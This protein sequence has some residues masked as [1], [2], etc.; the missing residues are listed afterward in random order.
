MLTENVHDV[1]EFGENR[2]DHT[3]H[4]SGARPTIRLTPVSELVGSADETGQ[5]GRET[6]IVTNSVSMKRQKASP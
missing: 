2:V 3:D 5:R 4:L 6:Y 1:V